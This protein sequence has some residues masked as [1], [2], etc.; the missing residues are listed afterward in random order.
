MKI[1]AVLR[2][3]GGAHES[4]DVMSV[5]STK[6]LA[7]AEAERLNA[8]ASKGYECEVKEWELDTQGDTINW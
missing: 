3:K 4:R 1:F 6:P 5:W 2:E 8:Y 7:Q